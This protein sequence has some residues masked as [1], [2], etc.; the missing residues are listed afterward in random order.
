MLFLLR[1]SAPYYLNLFVTARCNASCPYCL[2]R[3]RQATHG[4]ELRVGEYE[5]LAGNWPGLR[6]LSLTGGE[7]FLREDLLDILRAFTRSTR[8]LYLTIHTNGFD[9]AALADFLATARHEDP[10]RMLNVC[11]S[12]D[13]IGKRHDEIRG[14]PG[15]F[16]RNMECIEIVRQH[17]A[18]DKRVDLVTATTLA[19]DNIDEAEAV[20]QFL[21][22][23]V[24]VI[25]TVGIDRYAK[26][27]A[28]QRLLDRFREIYSA[29]PYYRAR[30][31][32][33]SLRSFRQA[34]ESLYP[35][36]LERRARTGRREMPCVAGRNLIVLYEDGTAAP[37]EMRDDVFGNVRDA[38]YSIEKLLRS[39]ASRA[40]RKAIARRECCCLWENP[41]PFS[42]VYA[43]SRYPGILSRGIRLFRAP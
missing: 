8:A 17:R 27:P 40:I 18:A 38:D 11:L 13:G 3:F 28:R 37:C 19:E 20:W 33:F 14:V 4:P 34:L 43:P 23:E 9:P 2:N 21:T 29:R 35:D 24:G 5:R 16:D 41:I 32:A 7:P 30:Y 26:G 39:P 15:L 25:S 12:F 1:H 6:I 36:E 10:V 31:P 22:D 42:L